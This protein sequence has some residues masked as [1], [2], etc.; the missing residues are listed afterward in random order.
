MKNCII[1][2]EFNPFHN[3]HEYLIQCVKE[4]GYNVICLMSGNI[5]Q[6]GELAIISKYD[7]AYIALKAGANLILEYPYSFCC[8]S[9]NSFTKNAILMANKFG[10]IDTIAFGSECDSLKSLRGVVENIIKPDF[11][12]KVEKISQHGNRYSNSLIEEYEKIYGECDIL[13]NSNDILNIGYLKSIL[14]TNSNIVP[15][16]IKRIGEDYNSTNS[17]QKNISARHIRE[18]IT[19]NKIELTKDSMPNYAY[20]IILDRIKNG[21]IPDIEKFYQYIRLHFQV[22]NYDE[23]ISCNLELFNR[24]QN[25]LIKNTTYI[26]FLHD[27]ENKIYSQ[28]KIKREIIHLLTNMP[29]E[30]ND[31]SYFSQLLGFDKIGREILKSMKKSSNIPIITKQADYKTCLDNVDDYQRNVLVNRIWEWS[32]INSKEFGYNYKHKPI[33]LD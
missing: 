6:R 22:L 32:L 33:S 18:L 25:S 28:S 11:L 14:E 26:D 9:A 31:S 29:K 5:T 4:M 19:D 13:H 7:R 12:D 15:I 21:L 17:Q 16:S 24:I 10:I 8:S 2:S 3:G 27:V 20:D 23:N 30:I 1:I